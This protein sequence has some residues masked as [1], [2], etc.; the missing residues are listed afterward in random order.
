MI[1][2]EFEILPKCS[3][4]QCASFENSWIISVPWSFQNFLVEFGEHKC[5]KLSGQNADYLKNPFRPQSL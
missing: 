3:S 5:W 4:L 1:T 2:Y